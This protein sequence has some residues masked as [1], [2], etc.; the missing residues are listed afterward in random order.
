MIRVEVYKYSVTIICKLIDILQTKLD[1]SM[2]TTIY[3]VG[4]YLWLW[5]SLYSFL[6][7]E[8]RVTAQ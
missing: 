4:F 6:N 2:E 7:Y 8:L 1:T 3:E 5:L